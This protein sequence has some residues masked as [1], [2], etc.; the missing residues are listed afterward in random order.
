MAWP[1]W[2]RED[3]GDSA[4]RD[5]TAS[6][7]P[8]GSHPVVFNCYPVVRPLCLSS[9]SVLPSFLLVP[10]QGEGCREREC[11]TRPWKGVGEQRKE[12]LNTVRQGDGTERDG[13]RVDEVHSRHHWEGGGGRPD[14]DIFTPSGRNW[15]KC[16][17]RWRHMFNSFF[18]FL[19]PVGF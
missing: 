10:V 11:C 8:L 1:G 17:A 13:E 15:E 19:R 18:F 9:A 12:I 2:E 16:K 14:V 4:P 5:P 3:L 6:Q 7:R